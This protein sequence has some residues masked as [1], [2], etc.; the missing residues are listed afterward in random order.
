MEAATTTAPRP[1]IEPAERRLPPGP[2]LPRLAQTA[3]WSR[4]ARRMLYA[5]QDRYG[6]IFRLKIVG[7]GTWV[8]LADPEAVKQVFTGD[9]RVF[10]AGEGNQLLEPLLGPHS[11]LVLDEKPHISQ[12]KLLLPPFHGERMQ[13]YGEIMGEIAE[14]EIAGW[15]TGAPYQLRPRM[16]ALTLE[17]ILRTVFGAREGE[18]LADLRDA[19]RHFLE[20]L[21]DPKQLLP[22][23]AVGPRRIRRLPWFR[24]AM[25]RVD[26]L[27][28]REVAAR[29]RA[30]DLEQ[31]DDVLSM[32]IAARHEDGSPMSDEEIRDELLTL[33][34]AGHETTATSLAWAVERLCRHP[35][36]MERLRDEVDAGEDAYLTATIQ[37][38]LRLR[39]VIAIVLRRLTEPVEIGGYE[40]PAGVSVAPSIYLVHRNPE[41]Y[42]DPESFRPER[43]LD[44]PPGTYTWIPF[45][46]GVRRCLGAAFAQFEMAVVLRELVRRRQ[47]RPADPKP[48]RIFRRAITE[49]PRHNTEVILS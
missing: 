20:L 4:R 21:T 49:T 44:E 42:P 16:Q 27:I 13:A 14:R 15:P 36:K 25:D 43:F 19:L 35:Q 29:R 41:I 28:Y 12:R 7:E 3:I 10:H 6:D 39:P 46:G 31:R 30:R 2:P 5:C 34:T 1:A 33:L 17:I 40:L 23:I 37:E 9:P 22:V 26:A 45:G 48:E 11:L 18:G 24:R 47:I 38:T 8:M 32:L